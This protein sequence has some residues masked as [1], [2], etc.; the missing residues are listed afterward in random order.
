MDFN[1]SEV[2]HGHSDLGYL[3]LVNFG[4]LVGILSAFIFWFWIPG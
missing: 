3:L 4:D 2:A 1:S